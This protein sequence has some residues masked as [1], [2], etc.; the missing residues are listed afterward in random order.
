MVSVECMGRL[1]QPQYR[2]R[3]DALELMSKVVS[4]NVCEWKENFKSISHKFA[5]VIK[6]VYCCD[7]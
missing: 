5:G 4:R 6:S 1:V 2:L 3:Q 7:K